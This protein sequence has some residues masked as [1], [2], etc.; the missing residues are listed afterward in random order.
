MPNLPGLKHT[1]F[2]VLLGTW[3]ILRIGTID[4]PA[5]INS[6]TSFVTV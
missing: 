1:M 2:P 6:M 4:K 5:N 3:T